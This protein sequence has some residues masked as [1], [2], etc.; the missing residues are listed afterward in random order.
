[1]RDFAH[2]FSKLVWSI[3]ETLFF[4]RC[5]GQT[6]QSASILSSLLD[7]GAPSQRSEVK[8]KRLP[9]EYRTQVT[10]WE[11]DRYLGVL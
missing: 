7:S 8:K 3:L 6:S 5:V 2:L 10:D 4:F 11:I 9:D 1:M